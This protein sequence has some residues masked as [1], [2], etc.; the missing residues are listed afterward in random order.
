LLPPNFDPSWITADIRRPSW[1][2]IVLDRFKTGAGEFAFWSA[3]GPLIGIDEGGGCR[4]RFDFLIDLLPGPPGL[5]P[6]N[7][8]CPALLPLPKKRRPPGTRTGEK[9]KVL[10]SFGAGDPGGFTVPAA[11]EAGAAGAEVRAILGN[12]QRADREILETLGVK[13]SGVQGGLR[14]R[15]AEYDLVIT[16]FG[17]TA[18]EALYAGTAVLLVSPSAY[19][20][21]LARRSGFVS[22]GRKTKKLG[23]RLTR[24]GAMEELYRRCR[25]LA[26]RYGLAER[27]KQS[28]GD[29]IAAM[30]P[31][32]ARGCPVCG[33]EQN[34]VLARFPDRSYRICSRCGMVR[35]FRPVP[36][37]IR[38]DGDYFFR[39]Y[40][41]QYGKTYLEDFPGLVQG[42]RRR[43]G[44]IVKLLPPGERGKLLDIG[45]AYG[46]FL[47]AA[48]EEGFSPLG[49]DPSRDAIGHVRKELKLRGIRGFFPEDI[50]GDAV[51]GSFAVI[52]LWYVMEHF[53]DTRRI[54]ETINRL[55]KPGGI[56]A[57]SSPS[58]SGISRRVS[59]RN[60]LTNSPADHWTI[61]T[62]RRCGKILAEF[63]FEL[64]QTVI[65]GHHPERFPLFPR[66]FRKGGAVY[67]AVYGISRLFG[68]GDTFEAYAVKRGGG[69]KHG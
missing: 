35:M 30:N 43:L 52:S 1:D 63:G 32:L 8:F 39:D 7:I 61:W 14:E 68:L 16:H 18:F 66:K 64:K 11:R 2:C 53:R 28:L 31:G 41:K 22:L 9:V 55:L 54:L 67:W 51:P 34:R 20:E 4:D 33:E 62:P 25:R 37:E 42:A 27:A 38:Y 6:P 5:V 56:L 13:L 17:L 19:H 47:A 44:R 23:E 48:R 40:K 46:P 65:T 24:P 58:F 36:P 10:V 3:R 50:P 26:E 49:M 60:F 69:K 15:L 45:C 57:F 21:K 59:C 29:R 12:A